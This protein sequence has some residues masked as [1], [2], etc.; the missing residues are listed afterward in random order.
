M[1]I[2]KNYFLQPGSTYFLAVRTDKKLNETL[3][4]AHPSAIKL[5]S[6]NSNLGNNELKAVALKAT[7]PN[8]INLDID[9]AHGMTINSHVSI[10]AEQ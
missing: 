5:V 7:Y 10:H 1:S 8:E 6:D 2:A 4:G 3:I 9:V